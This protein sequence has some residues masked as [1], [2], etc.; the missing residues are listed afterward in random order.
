[1][2]TSIMNMRDIHASFAKHPPRKPLTNLSAIVDDWEY[3]FGSEGMQKYRRDDA[4]EQCA[5]AANW[6]NAVM[7]ACSTNTRTDFAKAILAS[8]IEKAKSFDDLHDRLDHIRPPGIGPITCYIVATRLA[9]FL[10]L[11]V[12]SLYLHGAT[13]I[14]WSI[15]HGLT[16]PSCNLRI[17]RRD[18]PAQLQ[19][20]PTE[21]IEDMLGAYQNYLKPWL[22]DWHN[23]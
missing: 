15:L 17:Y 12:S 19:R 1:M 2:E 4:I 11:E 18:L 9:A 5:I 3:R 10:K 6:T 21:Q 14:A 16:V 7:R 13:K 22:R 23:G 20:L 8:S